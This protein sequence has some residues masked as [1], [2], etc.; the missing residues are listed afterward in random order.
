MQRI[1][2]SP[3]VHTMPTNTM[4]RTSL[5]ALFLGLFA[6]SAGVSQ[7][8]DGYVSL[9]NGKDLTGWKQKGGDALYKVEDGAIVGTV[10]DENRNTFLC[11]DKE[12]ENFIFKV[13]FKFD[14]NFNSGI[15]FRSQARTEGERQRVFGYQ[16]EIDPAG[17]TAAIYDENRRDRWLNVVTD[18][19]RKGTLD[20]FKQGEWNEMEIQCVGPSIR[21]WLNGRPV[22]DIM[23]TA[24]QSGFIILQVHSS[25]TPGQ[26]RWRN[27]RIKELPATPWISFFKDGKFEDI[28][29]KPAGEWKFE[30]DGV[31]VFATSAPGTVNDGLVVSKESYDNFAVRLSFKRQEGNSGLYFRA[32]EVDKSYGL[33]GFQCEIEQGAVSGGLWEVEGRGWVFKPAEENAKNYRPEWNDVSTVAI[34]DRI[35]TNLNGTQVVDIIDPECM[36]NGK[37]GIQLHGGGGVTYRFRNYEIMPLSKE[38]VELIATSRIIE[39]NVKMMQHQDEMSQALI[40]QVLRVS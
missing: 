25:K 6:L 16:A 26:I 14:A 36:K 21:T 3:F 18:E 23:D 32:A 39:T 8:E 11:S 22:T 15:Q 27:I 28:D 13:E 17:M 30:E 40:S 35:V 1:L 24:T 12:F 31:T 19:F 9:F 7:A 4:F 5:H 2:T 34:G 38:M 33:R 10:N 37:T 29:I 20:A